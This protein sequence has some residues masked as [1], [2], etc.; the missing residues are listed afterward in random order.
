MVVIFAL[1]IDGNARGD[2]VGGIAIALSSVR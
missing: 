2:A 1:A